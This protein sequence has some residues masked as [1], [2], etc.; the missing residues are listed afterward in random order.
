[1][2]PDIGTVV[3]LLLLERVYDGHITNYVNVYH[4]DGRPIWWPAAHILDGWLTDLGWLQRG[5]PVPDRM[6]RVELT[7]KG[8]ARYKALR[9]QAS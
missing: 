8:Q 3:Q 6:R 4:D 2:T 7:E 9:E 5:E 1:M